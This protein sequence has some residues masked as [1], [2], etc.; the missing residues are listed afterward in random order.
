MY[1]G[2]AQLIQGGHPLT[3]VDPCM[4]LIV[5]ISEII[6]TDMMTEP[7]LIHVD[8]DY[9]LMI[10]EVDS[11][12]K[13]VW[14]HDDKQGWSYK[15]TQHGSFDIKCLLAEGML[16]MVTLTWYWLRVYST[17]LIWH[18]TGWDQVE[19]VKS[20]R[21]WYGWTSWMILYRYTVCWDYMVWDAE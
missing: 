9:T 5:R 2:S 16:N 11:C 19:Y 3:S 14:Y 18:Y 6:P 15:Q 10:R 21:W 20:C 4:R 1:M 8:L 12:I 7:A 17:W 13:W